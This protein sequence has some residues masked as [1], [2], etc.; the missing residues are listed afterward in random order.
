MF[1]RLTVVVTMLVVWHKFGTLSNAKAQQSGGASSTDVSH[2]SE[3]RPE[4]Y[5]MDI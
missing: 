4:M 1:V 5:A 2:L 3:G